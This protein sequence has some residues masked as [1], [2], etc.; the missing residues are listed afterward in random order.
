MNFKTIFTEHKIVC[1]SILTALAIFFILLLS[2]NIG[3]SKKTYVLMFFNQKTGKIVKEKRALLVPKSKEE[4]LTIYVED[5]LLGPESPNLVSLFT[6]ETTVKTCLLRDKFAYIDLS[7]EALETK[8]DF[9]GLKDSV[10]LFKKN[11]CTNFKNI[12]KIYMYIDGIE[13]YSENLSIAGSSL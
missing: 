2:V 9:L 4:R 8:D 12:A 6:P 5:L 3:D 10:N 13:V 1:C 7:R 11:V